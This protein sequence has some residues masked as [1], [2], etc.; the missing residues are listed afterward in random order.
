[1]RRSNLTHTELLGVANGSGITMRMQIIERLGLPV[2]VPISL[3]IRFT[4]KFARLLLHCLLG[5]FIYQDRIM[6]HLYQYIM[7][8]NCQG[9]DDRSHAA[10]AA[11]TGLN[12]PKKLL[13]DKNS[14]GKQSLLQQRNTVPV[15]LFFLIPVDIGKQQF[16]N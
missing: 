10:T 8:L 1:M 2:P 13:T 9:K 4:H 7:L 11:T 3:L 12:T 5:F 15:V 16:I 14:S 6:R